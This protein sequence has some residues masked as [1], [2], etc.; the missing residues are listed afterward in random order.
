MMGTHSLDGHVA[1]ERLRYVGTAGAEALC[2]FC[3]AMLAPPLL[4]G[5]EVVVLTDLYSGCVAKVAPT[6][7]QLRSGEVCL[8]FGS[9]PDEVSVFSTRREL[10]QRL[11]ELGRPAWFPPLR[12]RDAGD[13]HREVLRFAAS[14]D[15]SATEQVDWNWFYG[16]V[17]FVWQRRLPVEPVELGEILRH[18]AVP[19]RS[20]PILITVYE[21]GRGILINTVGRR[22]IQKNRGDYTR[23]RTRRPSWSK[24]ATR[25]SG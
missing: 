6:V 14:H 16:L 2:P 25:S 21:H 9:N 24:P 10:A 19:E 13:L 12:L 3:S 8:Q 22:P 5:D 20:L 7:A 15:W 18:H 11:P 23:R 17:G 4:P 1:V